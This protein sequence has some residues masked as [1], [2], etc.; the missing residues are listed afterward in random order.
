MIGYEA[1]LGCKDIKDNQGTPSKNLSTHG[2][3][4][5]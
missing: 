5:H 4:K 3:E 1:N 2:K